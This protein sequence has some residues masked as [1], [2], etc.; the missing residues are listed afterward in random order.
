MH[1]LGAERPFGGPSV[2]QLARGVLQGAGKKDHRTRHSDGH[3]RTITGASML[4]TATIRERTPFRQNRL[5][6]VLIVLYAVVWI[7]T[8]IN[9]VHVSDWVLENLL[10]VMFIPFLVITYRKYP[11]SDVSY[12]LITLF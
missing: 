9:P 2:Q 7:I 1:A 11:L 10:V 8:A 6:H 3:V 12:L 4:T 5:L